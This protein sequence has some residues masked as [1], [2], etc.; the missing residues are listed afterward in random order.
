MVVNLLWV[1]PL[2]RNGEVVKTG[3]LISKFIFLAPHL[4][5]CRHQHLSVAESV[6]NWEQ[7][8]CLVSSSFMICS[9]S[10]D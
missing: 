9:V 2:I 5:A 8:T 1:P 4:T 10:A 7:I 6:E 3:L